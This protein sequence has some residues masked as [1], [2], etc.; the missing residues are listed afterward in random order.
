M[1][2]IVEIGGK[3]YNVEKNS[4]I[5]IEK[6]DKKENDKVKFDKVLLIADGDKV[7]IGQPYVKNADVSAKVIGQIKGEQLRIITSIFYLMGK[8]VGFFNQS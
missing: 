8:I 6:I 7:H 4:I 2:A 1:Y 3:Q 5:N